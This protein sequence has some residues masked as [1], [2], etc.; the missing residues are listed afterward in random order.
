MNK[1]TYS[2]EIL[3]QVL[4]NIPL[5]IEGSNI[6]NTGWYPN[7]EWDAEYM[8]KE[9]I[10]EALEEAKKQD[11]KVLFKNIY[12]DWDRCDC[13]DGMC[14]HGSFVVGMSVMNNEEKIEIDFVDGDS[15]ESTHD[16]SF[17]L[18]TKNATIYDFYRMCELVGIKLEF[19]DY[20]HSLLQ[21]F[22]HFSINKQAFDER[23]VLIKAFSDVTKE[24]DGR[25]WIREGR[26]SYT[27]DD[28]GYRNE[29]TYLFEAF[30]RIK[31]K[32][33]S[34]IKSK[35]FE[36]KNQVEAPLLKNIDE[37]KEQIEL[38]KECFAEFIPLDRYDEAT[39]FLS[40]NDGLARELQRKGI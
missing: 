28:E 38:Y 18:P 15:L 25:E 11:E 39:V 1:K 10:I 16:S 6:S 2:R 7:P 36:Y 32:M 26:G 20:A 12:L 4:S 27:Y 35:T 17:I 9:E 13:N 8:T 21:S 29:V 14:S 31:S 5:D 22:E 24:F 34:N 40:A 33:W 37:L 3:F 23:E 19:S 30:K